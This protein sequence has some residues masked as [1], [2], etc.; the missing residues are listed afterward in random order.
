ML[1]KPGL[2]RTSGGKQSCFAPAS[3][4]L[5]K[6]RGPFWAPPAAAVD[7]HPGP[8]HRR[9]S[10]CTLSSHALAGAGSSPPLLSTSPSRTSAPPIQGKGTGR[11]SSVSRPQHP[12]L[13]APTLPERDEPQRQV[14]TSSRCIPRETT[15]RA[16]LRQ[17]TVSLPP[18]AASVRAGF[19]GVCQGSLPLAVTIGYRRTWSSSRPGSASSIS[20]DRPPE[21]DLDA[22]ARP[23]P[24]LPPQPAEAM[25]RSACAPRAC[26]YSKAP[27]VQA[28]QRPRGTS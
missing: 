18:A 14:R 4:S 22:A 23:A 12:L 16:P 1:S 17:P 25:P 19:A 20:P 27:I 2:P 13:L 28:C 3:G 10:V 15:R 9:L 24:A 8:R 6:H 11:P 26:P 5:T 21:P 7:L